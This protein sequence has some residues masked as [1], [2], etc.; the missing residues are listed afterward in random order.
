MAYPLASRAGM[1]L[2]IQA[3]RTRC[4]DKELRSPC[5]PSSSDLI[6][7]LIRFLQPECIKILLEGVEFDLD[8]TGRQ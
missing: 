4:Q 3:A 6:G 8:P 2:T 5:G 1:R 7:P